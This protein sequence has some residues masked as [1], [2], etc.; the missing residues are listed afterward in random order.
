MFLMNRRTGRLWATLFLAVSCAAPVKNLNPCHDACG[1]GCGQALFE[2]PPIESLSQ[3]SDEVYRCWLDP[4]WGM[5]DM[6]RVEKKGATHTLIHKDYTG[7]SS[8]SQ[9]A[10][11]GSD[12]IST[13]RL[14]TPEEWSE[15]AA[16]TEAARFWDVADTQSATAD[17]AGD[18]PDYIAQ[19]V[20]KDGSRTVDARCPGPNAPARMCDA[21][22]AAAGI[23]TGW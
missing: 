16:A 19:G 18:C 7:Q 17:R 3:G 2:E 23:N 9:A 1:T 20:R 21:L 10:E 15:I 12:Y 11:L 8:T 5:S 22:F 13:T 6:V 4:G 14:L